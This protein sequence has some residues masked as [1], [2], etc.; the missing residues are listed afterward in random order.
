MPKLSILPEEFAICRLDP[1]STVP[2]WALAGSL[3]SVTRTEDELS[4]VCAQ[5]QAPEGARC[6]REWRCMKVHGPLDFSLTGV[7]AS[8]VSPLAEAGISIFA[9]STFDTDYL[10]VKAGNLEPAI[11]ALT[12]AGH[13][14]LR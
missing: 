14:I 8:L 9:F 6:D 7:L 3:S 11:K 1:N 13:E 12:D 4:I 2:N 10:M 5:T